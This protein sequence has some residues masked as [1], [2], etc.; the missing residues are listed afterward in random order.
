MAASALNLTDKNGKTSATDLPVGLYLL[1]ETKVPEMVTSTVNPFFVSLPIATI[2]GNDNSSSPEGGTKWNYDVAVYPK[3][4]TGI[5]PL[6]KAVREANADTGKNNGTASI[7]DGFAHTAT[8]SAGDLM[9]YQFISTLPTITSKATALSVYS[10]YDSLSEG[11]TYSK[12]TGVT[13]EFFTDKD[14]TDKVASWAMDSGKFTVAYSED[15]RHM[16]IGVTD[17]G[18]TEVNNFISGPSEQRILNRQNHDSESPEITI[19]EPPKPRCSNTDSNHTENND[20]HLSFPSERTEE[21]RSPL[22]SDYYSFFR[23]RLD[24]D[25]ICHDK[26]A[27]ADLTEELLTLIV[28]TYCTSQK[29]IRIGRD[30][31]PIEVVRSQFMKLNAEH[32]RFVIRGLHENRTK[33]K[34]IRQYLLSAI[35]NAPLTMSGY[36]TARVSHDL[37]HCDLPLEPGASL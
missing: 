32:I 37:Y 19:Q 17:M 4:E 24:I 15:G 3:N 16:T 35:Y 5:P 23:E 11:L 6:E 2:S 31:K 9:E 30:D 18:L 8:G 36:Y 7:T 13:V 12:D 22:Y 33:V 34:N 26:P 1:V 28:D 27:D 10:F 14:C 29:R 25:V 20:N 21:N